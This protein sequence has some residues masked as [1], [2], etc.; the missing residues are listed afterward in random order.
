MGLKC[1]PAINSINV[2][3]FALFWLIWFAF[4][5]LMGVAF[6]IPNMDARNLSLLS[7]EEIHLFQTK[8]IKASSDNTLHDLQYFDKNAISHDAILKEKDSKKFTRNIALVNPNNYDN[9]IG[10]LDSDQSSIL[11]QFVRESANPL[12]PKKKRFS[13]LDVVG[14][15][16]SSY[17]FSDSEPYLLY[18][19]E[20]VNPQQEFVNFIFDHPL[21]MLSLLMITSTPLLILLIFSLTR[22][23]K[24]LR[25][26]AN[27]ISHGHLQVMPELESSGPMELREVGKSFNQMINSVDNV[28][29][30]QQRLLSDISHE[31]RTPLTR[32]QLATSLLR[33]RNG[34]T[35]E[36]TR[37]ETEIERMDKMIAQLLQMSRHYFTIEI[38]RTAF[39]IVDIWESVVEDAYFESQERNIVFIFSQFIQHPEKLSMMG[40]SEILARALENVIRN[41]FKYANGEVHLTTTQLHGSKLEILVDDNGEGVP[42]SEYERIFKPFYRTD[43]A[44]AR[45]TGGTGLGLSIVANAIEQHGGSVQASKSPLGGLRIQIILPLKL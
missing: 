33:R 12:E 45:T 26:A 21:I 17:P 1:Y 5:A 11:Y 43:E 7:D 8:V 28:I 9:I 32:L 10:A 20:T 4:F 44:R 35:T 23:I 27:D 25:N 41:A 24:R 22:P 16:V 40:N 2:K 42:E 13:N 3:I 29:H 30:S 38:N 14:P 34:E 6:F 39:P 37:I 18:F 15:F 31:L 19:I 36:V